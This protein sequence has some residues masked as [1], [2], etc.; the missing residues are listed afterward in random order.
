MGGKRLQRTTLRHAGS[1]ALE[2]ASGPRQ[3]FSTFAHAGF[4]SPAHAPEMSER[5]TMVEATM[6]YV[7]VTIHSPTTLYV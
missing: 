3:V 5:V 6:L 7:M 4:R 1:R 2:S